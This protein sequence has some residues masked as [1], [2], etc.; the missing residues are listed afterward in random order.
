MMH[1]P[2]DLNSIYD[3]WARPNYEVRVR[4]TEPP[5]FLWGSSK[6]KTDMTF[7]RPLVLHIRN[8]LFGEEISF[9]TQTSSGTVTEYGN[10]EPGECAS[11]QLQNISGVFATC[12]LES[13]VAC[14][15]NP[16]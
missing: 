8:D 2:V 1:T 3:R 6:I 13:V 12:T 15:I 5:K 4:G 14:V 7:S 16:E 11:I 10:L 9:G